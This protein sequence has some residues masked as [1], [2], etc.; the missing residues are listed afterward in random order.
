MR[1]PLLGAAILITLLLGTLLVSCTSPGPAGPATNSGTQAAYSPVVDV[2]T[3]ADGDW[4]HLF[5]GTDL[6]GWT[7]K[8]RGFAPGEDPQGTF[9]VQNGAITVSYGN[10]GGV[11]REQFGHLFHETPYGWYHLEVE[12]RFTGDQIADGP[13]WAWRNSGVMVHGQPVATMGLDQDFPASIEVQLLGGDGTDPR[14]TANLCTP[15][16]NVVY[17]GAL[18]TRHCIESSSETY[19]GDGWVRVGITVLGDSLVVHSV[20]GTEVLRYEMP[21]LGGGSVDGH[22]PAI[23]REG[24]LLAQ[25]TISLQ[26]ESH[27]VQFRRVD[28]LPLEGCT[29]PASPA[30]R[31]Y[32]V[33]SNA[34]ACGVTL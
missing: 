25:G 13:G 32:F 20:E 30:F 10:Y 33:R 26:S 29:D 16:T 4:V 15:G 3:A 28:L 27:P 23:L 24:E 1:H 19:P 14:T 9:S 6:T 21:Q 2:Q 11:F 8:V 18:D 7:P 5:N 34:S 12:Y 31:P 17:Q 22:D